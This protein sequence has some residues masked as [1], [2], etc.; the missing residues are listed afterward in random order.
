MGRNMRKAPG[1]PPEV[2]AAPKLLSGGNPQIAKGYGDAPVQAYIAAMP[3]W[4][5]EVGRRLDA[6]VE[7]A[8]PGAVLQSVPDPFPSPTSIDQTGWLVTAALQD[9]EETVNALANIDV[10]TRRTLD[11][12]VWALAVDGVRPLPLAVIMA[13]Y[14]EQPVL[15]L[16]G[17][18]VKTCGS[19]CHATCC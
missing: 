4:K 6:L 3:G 17:V 15:P 8:V 13:H 12:N 7:A 5:S 2:A 9:W 10:D 16:A 14:G 11:C 1:A 18:I 19:A